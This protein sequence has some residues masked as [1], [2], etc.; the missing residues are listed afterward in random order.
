MDVNTKRSFLDGN[1]DRWVDIHETVEVEVEV[2]LGEVEVCD[3]DDDI[4]SFVHSWHRYNHTDHKAVYSLH[5]NHQ[6]DIG[7]N[8]ADQDIGI[9]SIHLGIH[10]DDIHLVGIHPGYIHFPGCCPG[11]DYLAGNKDGV[12]LYPFRPCSGKLYENLKD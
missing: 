12:V 5:C 2:E 7:C 3:T 10:L 1:Q 11:V 4:H 8:I 9:H 6:C